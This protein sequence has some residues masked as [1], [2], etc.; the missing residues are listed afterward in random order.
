MVKSC[1]TVPPRLQE[2]FVRGRK[3]GDCD[4]LFGTGKH[5]MTCMSSCEKIYDTDKII[6]VAFYVVGGAGHP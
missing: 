5:G 6:G 1:I 2:I 4:G 3:R